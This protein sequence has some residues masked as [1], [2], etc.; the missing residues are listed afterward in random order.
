MSYRDLIPNPKVVYVD[1]EKENLNFFKAIF[2]N[3]YDIHTFDNGLEA[4][5]FLKNN[6][7]QIVITDQRMPHM[8]GVELLDAVRR[9]DN[10]IIT[11]LITA[12]HDF[13]PAVEAINKGEIYHYITKPW[14]EDYLRIIIDRALEKYASSIL[15]EV[16]NSKLLKAN[17]ELDRFIYSASHDLRAPLTSIVGLTRLIR[18]EET[19]RAVAEYLDMIDS[20]AEKLEEALK[21]FAYF[22]E[23]MRLI[24]KPEELKDVEKVVKKVV[25]DVAERSKDFSKI[26]CTIKVTQ[27]SPFKTEVNR[28]RIVLS[29]L[30]FNAANFQNY[31]AKE[32]SVHVD[33]KVSQ[34]K[35]TLEVKDNGIGISEGIKDRVFDMFFRGSAQSRGTG[36]GLYIV[37]D[38]VSKLRGDIYFE[39]EPG[40]TRFT[41]VLNE[42]N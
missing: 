21:S 30:L 35:M 25:A 31:D 20:S 24:D 32:K 38:A 3:H 28:F 1:D 2:R 41:V 42:M 39:S 37:K 4:L 6:D 23:N 8:T 5:D 29:H 7:V 40:N 19:S 16:Q 26:N 36:I 12:Y 22:S 33:V 9:I 27:K 11:M 14:E 17:K 13:K 18:E 15:L 34:A 10:R